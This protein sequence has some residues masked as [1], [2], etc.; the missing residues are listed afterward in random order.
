[1][2]GAGQSSTVKL[3][4]LAREGQ[5]DTAA[6]TLLC[7]IEREKYLLYLVL[8]NLGTVVG[9]GDTR[10]AAGSRCEH[11]DVCILNV[12]SSLHSVADDVDQGE[13]QQACIGLKD[14]IAGGLTADTAVS[15]LSGKQRL[16]MSEYLS[17]GDTGK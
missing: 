8:G 3:H 1:M 6:T 5:A 17:G 15:R 11:P 14:D 9:D 7:G 2:R 10:F 16:Q 13:R 12:V 4:Y